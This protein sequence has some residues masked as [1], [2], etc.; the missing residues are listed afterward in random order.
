MSHWRLCKTLQNSE[1]KKNKQQIKWTS[2]YVEQ[3]GPV[4]CYN[5][6]AA[7]WKSLLMLF[8]TNLS[9]LGFDSDAPFTQNLSSVTEIIETISKLSQYCL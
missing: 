6:R 5:K 4:G 1:K 9:S 2:K 7:L 3:E 8:L